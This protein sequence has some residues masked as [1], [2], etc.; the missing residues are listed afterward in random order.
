MMPYG[1]MWAATLPRNKI[2]ALKPV[3]WWRGEDNAL[4]SAG[5]HDGEWE[6]NEA[7]ADGAVGRAFDFDG[8]SYVLC[9]RTDA[10]IFGANPFSCWAW[11][12]S[13]GGDDFLGIVSDRMTG[14]NG[15]RFYCRGSDGALRIAVKGGANSPTSPTN[16]LDD[17]WHHVGAILTPATSNIEFFVDG[18]SDGSVTL[19]I[20]T[21][22]SGRPPVI[23]AYESTVGGSFLREFHGLI[24]ET[25][26]FNRALSPAEIAIIAD[27]KNYPR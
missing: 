7:Y 11:V 19:E 20:G 16:V 15:F 24:D 26:I 17:E 3:A 10:F 27:P 22:D 4:D 13:D 1:A 25:L 12:K 9:N 18:E 6:G 14:D 8:S 2:L 23:G 5:D 21:G